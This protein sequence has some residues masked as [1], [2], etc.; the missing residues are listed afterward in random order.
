[1]VSQ[2][3]TRVVFLAEDESSGEKVALCRFVSAEKGGSESDSREGFLKVIGLLSQVRH[4]SLRPVLEGGVDDVD[5]VPFVATEWVEGEVLGNLLEDAVLSEADGL[6]M[7][8]QALGLLDD[9]QAHT[10]SKASLLEFRPDDIIV[11]QTEEGPRFTFWATLSHFMGEQDDKEAVAELAALAG[12]C[13][14]ISAGGAPAES[15]LGE[16]LR[17]VRDNEPAV[18]EAWGAFKVIA[19]LEE[20][21]SAP[22][23]VLTRT[24]FPAASSPPVAP[25]RPVPVVKQ[26]SSSTGLFVTIGAVAVA[27]VIGLV[28][29]L[30]VNN[31]NKPPEVAAV[32][33]AGESPVEDAPQ[34][35]EPAPQ[36]PEPASPVESVPTP[37]SSPKEDPD[38]NVVEAA[39]SESSPVVESAEERFN[40]KM[41]ERMRISR[42]THFTANEGEEI[43]QKVGATVSVTGVVLAVEDFIA[44]GVDSFRFELG[45]A[46]E[47]T[48]VFIQMDMALAPGKSLE[49]FKEEYEGKTLTFRGTARML[50][51]SKQ[52]YLVIDSPEA[53]SPAKLE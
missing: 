39:P 23:R 41:E 32:E 45:Q 21:P 11:R 9:V 6:V 42:K 13:C 15:K 14:G 33:E 29:F 18:A 27:G 43:G 3:A 51:Y 40:R 48:G 10:G 25:S 20:N 30:V 44:S 50:T 8:F 46:E 52:A 31:M 7:V 47:S 5:G 4:P 12:R 22:D 38:P 1:M 53:I 26:P 37:E 17:Y 34:D 19:Q 16:W 2:D 28:V 36:D 49:D 24:P 35:P